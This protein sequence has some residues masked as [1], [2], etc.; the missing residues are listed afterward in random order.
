MWNSR[1]YEWAVVKTL[2]SK[3]DRPCPTAPILTDILDSFHPSRLPW[4][5][6]GF[7]NQVHVPPPQAEPSQLCSY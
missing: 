2:C 6:L 4:E 3:D 5:S 1:M 7:I